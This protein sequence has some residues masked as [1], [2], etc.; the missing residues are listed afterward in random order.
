MRVF[1]TG[2]TGFVGRYVVKKLLEEGFAVHLGVRNEEK[3]RRLFGDN[4]TIHRVDLSSRESIREVLKEV[5][6]SCI[7]HLVGI[8]Y[9]EKGKGITF[10]E[11]H[12]RYSVNLY[13][14]AVELGVRKAVHMSALGTHDDA[15]SR[16]HRTKRMAEKH[17][18]GS[19]ITYVIFRPSI[20][21]GPEQRLFADMDRI[22]KVLPVVALPGGGDYAFQPVDVRDVAECFAKAVRKAEDRKQDPGALRDEKGHL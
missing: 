19:G 6:P 20:I 21:L 2:G 12:Y 16:Y 11:V 10:E 13:D 3:A 4:V 17:L 9:E 1:V 18:I 7:V 15:P 5:K 22:T 14:V 8:L